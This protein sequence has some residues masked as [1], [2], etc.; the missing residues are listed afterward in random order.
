MAVREL[1]PPA[2]PGR[3]LWYDGNWHGEIPF[4]V[5]DASTKNPDAF[6]TEVVAAFPL[7]KPWSLMLPEL[8]VIQLD[9]ALELEEAGTSNCEWRGRAIYGPPQSG[10]L[11]S[12]GDVNFWYDATPGIVT[13]RV[14]SDGNPLS[15]NIE[16]QIPI[17]TETFFYERTESAVGFWVDRSLRHWSDAQPRHMWGMNSEDDFSQRTRVNECVNRTNSNFFHG[18]GTG[19]WLCRGASPIRQNDPLIFEGVEY[20]RWLVRYAFERRIFLQG[21]QQR[22][23]KEWVDDELKEVFERAD[24]GR[25]ELVWRNGSPIAA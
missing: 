8:R 21:N 23:W 14:D 15:A 20:D 18:E 22:H 12:A 13:T 9:M 7:G 16:L 6:L 5:I 24:F 19:K 17:V 3:R 2:S 10:G 25:L 11:G 4:A 1:R